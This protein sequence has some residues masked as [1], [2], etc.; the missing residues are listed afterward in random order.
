MHISDKAEYSTGRCRTATE[1]HW[2][3][4][5]QSILTSHFEREGGGGEWEGGLFGGGGG[6]HDGEREKLGALILYWILGL[7]ISVHG[8]ND[9]HVMEIE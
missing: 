3:I 8:L 9:E 6:G 7:P 4:L 5:I 2:N 1:T